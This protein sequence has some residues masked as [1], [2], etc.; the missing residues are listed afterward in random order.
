MDALDVHPDQ[1]AA[2]RVAAVGR[3][4]AAAVAEAGLNLTLVPETATAD[5]LAARLRQVCA[6]ER[7][8]SIHGRRWDETSFR[9][10]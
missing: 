3:A 2:M 1:L 10:S 5:A 9:T 6:R 8:S 7:G 4:T